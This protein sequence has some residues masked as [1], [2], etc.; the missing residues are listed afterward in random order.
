MG[1]GYSRKRLRYLRWTGCSGYLRRAGEESGRQGQE[2]SQPFW[3]GQTIA[4]LSIF[5]V[6]K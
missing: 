2:G 5:K 3:W 6:I 4:D 1:G